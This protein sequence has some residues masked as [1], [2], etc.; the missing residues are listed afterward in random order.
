LPIIAAMKNNAALLVIDV[1]NDFC[2]S[3]ALAVPQGDLVVPLINEIAK[4]FETVVITQDWHPANH[5]SFAASHSGRQAFETIQ[6]SYGEQVLWPTHCVMATEGAALHARLAIP[7]ANLLLRKG[8]HQGID[9]YS[10][11]LEADRKTKT[12]L[13]GYL[14]SRGITELYL[15][16]LALD[17]CVAWSAEDAVHFGFSATIIE[18][19]CKAIDHNNS[20]AL[21][22]QRLKTAGVTTT[23]STNNL[24]LLRQPIERH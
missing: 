11:F 9:S 5:T 4:Q 2:P 16:G 21:A 20:L 23:T 10:A 14:T 6:L 7:H 8:S 19:A 17:Y 13:D 1:Q 18:D 15:C 12:G 24:G 22:R 3:G